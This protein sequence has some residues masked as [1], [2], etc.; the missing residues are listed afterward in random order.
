MFY[1]KYLKRILDIIIAAILLIM[2]SPVFVVLAALIRLK[3]GS[4]ILFKQER[5]GYK[6]KLFLLYKF[7]TMTNQKDNKGKLLDDSI[8][9]TSFG[10]FLR[11]TSLDEL[12]EL[13][14]ILKGDMSFIGPRPLLVEYLPLYNDHQRDRHNVKPG[15]S[16]LAQV[17]GR[18]QISWE[19]KF[20]LDIQY[21]ESQSFKL[22][23]R[24]FFLTIKKVLIRE[25]ITSPTSETMEY[26]LGTN[27]EEA[28][29]ASKE[30]DE[31]FK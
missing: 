29:A 13:W 11:A 24:I 16:G 2:L 25:G 31:R 17:S 7:R 26:F 21:V 19:S 6:E 9:L 15:L 1:K 14:N 23:I 3:L 18:N 22:D 30:Q 28:F 20:D 10:K 8:R 4:P 27:T 5:P 12:P